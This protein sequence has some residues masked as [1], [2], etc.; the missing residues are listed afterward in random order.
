MFD[1]ADGLKLPQQQMF[2]LPERQRYAKVL[3]LQSFRFLISVFVSPP[4]ISILG[5]ITVSLYTLL[6]GETGFGVVVGSLLVLGSLFDRFG[7]VAPFKSRPS[8]PSIT[9]CIRKSTRASI[10]VKNETTK[11]LPLCVFLP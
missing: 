6:F 2:R 5:N 9:L 1:K 7:F 8:D 10:F 3:R 4:G 11:L